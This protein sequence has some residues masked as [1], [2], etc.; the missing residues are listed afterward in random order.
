MKSKVKSTVTTI[1]AA[2]LNS[3]GS[4]RFL[5]ASRG[6]NPLFSSKSRIAAI[7]VLLSFIPVMAD[8]LYKKANAFYSTTNP[9]AKSSSQSI[10]E[11]DVF[12]FPPTAFSRLAG[13]PQTETALFSVLPMVH[14]PFVIVV[15]NGARSGANR[16]SIAKIMLNGSEI[17]RPSDFNQNVSRLQ[18]AVNLNINNTLQIELRGKPGGTLT[19]S[20]SGMINPDRPIAQATS[21]VNSSGGVV[22]LANL[23]ELRI[24]PNTVTSA[25][26]SLTAIESDSMD[27]FT[28]SEPSFTPIDAPKFRIKSSSPLSGPVRLRVTVEGLSDLIPS[29]QELVFAALVRG[30]GGNGE[31]LDDVIIL[32]GNKCGIRKH[33]SSDYE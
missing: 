23:A 7:I 19:V 22:S 9:L 18:R 1:F 6:L 5:V 17:F 20:I 30:H 21:E 16:V 12:V 25:E 10:P 28:S 2:I 26:I 15:E 11:N 32:S 29:G 33:C 27:Y 13:P 8:L 4:K 31:E 3:N 14:A 24:P